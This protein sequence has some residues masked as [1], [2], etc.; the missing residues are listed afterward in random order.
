MHPSLPSVPAHELHDLI[1]VGFGPAALAIGVSLQDALETPSARSHLSCSDAAPPKVTF[2]EK[3]QDFAWHAGMQLSGAKM[4]ISWIKD[5]ATMRNPRSRFTFLNYL[6]ENERLVAFSNL[7]TFLPLRAEYEDYMRWCAKQFTNVEYS[8]EA[9]EVVPTK[10]NEKEPSEADGFIVRSRNLLTNEV[11]SRTTRHVVISTGGR[12][13]IPQPLPQN[14]P[15]VIHSA[16]Y[17]FAVPKLLADRDEHYRIAVIGGGQ[18]AAETFNDLHSKY[19]NSETRLIIR[20]GAL[21]PSDDSPFVNEIFDPDRVG[22]TFDTPSDV[23]AADLAQNKTTNY[24]VVRLPLLEQIYEGLYEQRLHH[25][26]ESHW[27]HRVL[28]YRDVVAIDDNSSMIGGPLKVRMLDRSPVHSGAGEPTEEIFD[29][30]LVIVAAGYARNGHEDLLHNAASLSSDGTN[31]WNVARDYSVQFRRG[32]VAPSAGV[33]LQ[34]CNEQTHGLSDT[35]LSV[36]ATRSWE[37]VQSIFGSRSSDSADATQAR[38]SAKAGMAPG[39][40]AVEKAAPVQK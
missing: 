14:N 6:F 26:D 8:Q 2:L 5:L 10:I 29:A 18:S 11:E 4:Q 38:S 13:T 9:I 1:C 17:K 32:A 20:G 22:S 36:L 19:P 15:R 7:G 35:L 33:W 34:G 37:V 27:P 30:D 25:G 24:G 40:A 21:K 16:H 12:P 31:K 23:R 28:N 39:A 3:Q